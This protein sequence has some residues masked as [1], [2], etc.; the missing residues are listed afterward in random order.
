MSDSHKA[1]DTKQ[2]LLW[3]LQPPAKGRGELCMWKEIYTHKMYF[4]VLGVYHLL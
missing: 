2:I 3:S 1:M 4:V